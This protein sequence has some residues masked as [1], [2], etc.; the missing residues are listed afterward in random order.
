MNNQPLPRKILA[1]D[2]EPGML[3]L[4]KKLLAPEGYVVLCAA[5]GVEGVRLNDLENP[6]LIILDLRMPEMGGIETLRRIR[7]HDPGVL[8]VILTGYGDSDS[9]RDAAD[10]NVSEF[11]GKPFDNRQLIHVVNSAFGPPAREAR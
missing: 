9:I 4:M 2:D 10:L 8:V 7:R 3:E 1:I 6:E 11:L 5:G